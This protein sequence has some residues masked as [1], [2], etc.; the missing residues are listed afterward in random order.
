VEDEAGVP[1]DPCHHRGVLV[2]RVVVEDDV[3]DLPGGHVG[4]N[5]VEKGDEFLVPLTLHAA[6]DGGALK[7]VQSGEQRG[8]AVPDVVVALDKKYRTPNKEIVLREREVA[9]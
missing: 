9:F 5:G 3:H 7:D 1:L 2:G 6:S 8:G 4:L